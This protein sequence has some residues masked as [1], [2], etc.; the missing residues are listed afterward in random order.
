M[1]E[2]ETPQLRIADL[3]QKR[4]TRDAARLK[5]YNQIL[6]QL[7]N[8]IK[9]LSRL[10]NCPC[11]L[12]YT[13]PPFI[14]GLPKIDLEDCVV[15]LTYQLRTNGFMVQ[16]TYP[17]LLYISWKHHEKNYI[18]EQS[19]ILQAMVDTAEIAKEKEKRGGGYS[20]V[21][22][23]MAPKKSVRPSNSGVSGVGM[24]GGIS[25]GGG[26]GRKVQFREER[27]FGA[28]TVGQ[29]PSA[30]DYVPPSSFIRTM[31]KPEAVRQNNVLGDLWNLK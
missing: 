28:P 20:R 15:Y 16:Y 30:G 8:R 9:G 4:H 29:I 2:L 12:L 21:M 23:L 6:S 17:N 31:E 14:I 7:Y 3:Y 18:L 19:P 26:G 11:Y 13:I 5:S 25:G 24:V 10:P 1:D 27:E 22:N